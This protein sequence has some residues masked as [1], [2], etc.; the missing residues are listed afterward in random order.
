MTGVF[1]V[2]AVRTPIGKFL[3]ALSSLPAPRL[4][5]A[6]IRAALARAKVDPER[7][8]E[9][10]MGNVLSAGVGQAPARQ[11]AIFGGL[12]PKVPCVTV[13][14][15]CGS[16]LKAVLMGAQA[17]RCGDADVV[18]AGGME[19]MS[20]AP[21]LL[22]EARTG[23]RLGHGR[24]LDSMIHDGLWD[25]YHEFHMGESCELV[26][27]EYKISREE[28]DAFAADSHRKAIAAI[29]AGAFRDEIVAVEVRGKK[30]VKVVDTDEGPRE[31]TSVA[32]L[33][34]LKPV[35]RPEGGRITAGN[36]SQINDGAAAVVLMSERALKSSGARPLARITGFGAGGVEPKWV[37]MSPVEAVRDLERRAGVRIRDAD[38]VEINEAFAAQVCALIR[39]LG[40]DPARLNVHGGAVALGHPIGAS[41]ARILVTLLYALHRHGKRTGVA[42]LCMGGGN[43]LAISVESV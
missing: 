2:S 15:V 25:P 42:T 26:C 18:V 19:S 1:I 21:Y 27:D 20:N 13:N 29:R 14:K 38:L 36:S 4:G 40:L 17:I 6:V 9:C 34:G 23:V 41:G 35:F 3:G 39:V 30:E 43:G 12:P 10:I 7:V 24:L 37:M 8:D 31:D 22:P 28:M 32:R 16:G 5:A 11:A 33:A